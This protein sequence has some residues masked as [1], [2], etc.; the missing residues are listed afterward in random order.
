MTNEGQYK[1]IFFAKRKTFQDVQ[2]YLE[3]LPEQERRE[4]I[5]SIVLKIATVREVA[6]FKQIRKG[7]E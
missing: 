2:D 1:V 7:R 5:R 3:T 6:R 4:I